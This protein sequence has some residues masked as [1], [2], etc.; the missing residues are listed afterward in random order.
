MADLPPIPKVSKFKI[1]LCQLKVTMDKAQ[2]IIEA[3]KSIEDAAQKGAMLVVLPEMWNCPYSSDNFSRFAEDFN[4]RNTSPSFM[5]LSEVAHS[6]GITIVG[7]SVPE[8]CG[9]RLYNTSCVFGADGKLIAKHRKVHLFDINMPGEISFK[10][11][12]IFTAGDKPTVVD[13][14]V[15]HIG[16]GICHDIR[17]PEL[18]MLYASRGVHLICYP[19][20]FNMSTGEALWE[21][22]FVATCSPARASSG[23][24]IIWGHSTLV[25][26]F[27][28]IIATAGCEE[29]TVIA[30]VDYSMIQLRRESLP[31]EKQKRGDIY[32]VVDYFMD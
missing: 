29:T 27:G 9:G 17:F 19:G 18:S 5:M 15:G 23:S 7:G 12:D 16:I 25:G 26:P 24:Y 32:K 1:A 3:C 10:E 22:L 20:A 28:E 11:S 21:L 14:D 31:L 13:T 30:E 2:N 4:D 6:Q 8:R